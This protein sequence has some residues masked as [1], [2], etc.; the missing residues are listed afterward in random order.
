VDGF[1]GQQGTF[2]LS[3]DLELTTNT[4]PVITNAPFSQTVAEGATA[5][6][7]VG[8]SGTGLTYQWTRNNEP[9][10]GATTATP[11]I[12]NVQAVDVGLYT[13]RISTARAQCRERAGGARDRAGGG[14]AVGGQVPGPVLRPG[15]GGQTFSGRTVTAHPGLTRA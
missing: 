9:L 1:A 10:V 14:R 12:M 15:A 7:A 2:I 3:W 11:T 5:T 8:V 4:V 13:V 6:F